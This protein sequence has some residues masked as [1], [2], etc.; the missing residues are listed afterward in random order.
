MDHFGE[1]GGPEEVVICTGTQVGKSEVLLN[2]LLYVIAQDPSPT[3]MVIP[4]AEDGDWYAGNRVRPMVAKCP[5]A[6]ERWDERRGSKLEWQFW[7]MSFTLSG[8]NSAAS[9][10]SKP[11]RFLF[12]DETD[13]YPPYLGDEGDPISLARERL[14]SFAGISK[15]VM[16]S[17]PTL[18][19]GN[20]WRHF[21]ASDV[22]RRYRV[23][24]PH[25]GEMQEL[26]WDRV[27]WP[28]ALTE[29]YRTARGDEGKTRVITQR[30]RGET[31]YECAR[32]GA[33]IEDRPEVRRE[34]LARGRW[35][36]VSPPQGPVRRVG[37][38]LSSLYSPWLAWGDCAAEFLGSKD[39]PEKLRNFLNSWLAEPWVDV[40][41]R[42]DVEDVLRRVGGNARGEVPREAQILTAGV[43]V[44]QD[45]L[46]W[47]VRA[48]GPGAASWLVDY[49]R[50]ETW[51]DVEDV[52]VRRH[53]GEHQVNLALL[54]SGYRT[55]EVYQ[56]CSQH[57][58]ICRPC[59]GAST[60][61][62]APTVISSVDR[63]RFG[64][65]KLVIVD[66]IYFKDFISGR[67]SRRPGD[68][69]AWTVC[70]DCPMEYA[71]H[72]CSE[73]R[74]RYQDRR[75]GRWV[76]EWQPTASHPENHLWDC[77]VYAA[78][79]AD[80]LGVRY[81]VGDP[82]EAPERVQA[83]RVAAPSAPEHSSAGERAPRRP[84]IDRR[85]W[86]R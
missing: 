35:G 50:A 70:G 72:I 9:L 81:L 68:A 77:E 49:G 64:L 13:K 85:R 1:D 80:L 14:K 19:S 2:C 15:C 29:A 6:A 61:Q 83:P 38:H 17:T 73:R 23:P 36:D 31:W 51:A 75:T 43:D 4:R 60:T 34:M 26:R 76:E 18:E 63:G 78:A 30:V 53:Y 11:I 84:W 37:Y 40:S 82:D 67:L 66:T 16:S 25:C 54:D 39:H 32:C 71:A 8:A 20:I 44:Q 41:S 79:A 33:R 56:F 42:R 22:Q 69:G 21:Q 28:E 74:V 5:R 24:C 59:K 47:T 65:L 46:W 12:L 45:H 57:P 10:A 7:G 48:W 27:R 52:I 3:M 58:E 62:R 55:D 86:G